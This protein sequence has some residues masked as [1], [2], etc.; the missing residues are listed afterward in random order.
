LA[1][2]EGYEAGAY[3]GDIEVE[4]I[5]IENVKAILLTFAQAQ[6]SNETM[7][8]ESVLEK[9]IEKFDEFLPDDVLSIGY[10]AEIFDTIDTKKWI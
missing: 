1:T 2:T 6:F 3:A 4:K 9:Q 10:G 8:A 5:S 7:L